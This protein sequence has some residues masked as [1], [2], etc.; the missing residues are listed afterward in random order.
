[1]KPE[2]LSDAII[3]FQSKH[4]VSD[5][6]LA[7]A[8]HLSVEKVHAMKQGRGNF[9]SDEINQMLDYLQSYLQS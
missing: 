3:E 2:E 5:T 6:T 8:S 9:T 1:M 4:T 7:F